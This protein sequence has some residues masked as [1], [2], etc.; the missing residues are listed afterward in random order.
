[1]LVQFRQINI[2]LWILSFSLRNISIKRIIWYL[3]N[4][5]NKNT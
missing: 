4:I 3:I 1:M 5:N 2:D